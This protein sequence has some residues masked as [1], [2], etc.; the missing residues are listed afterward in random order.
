MNNIGEREIAGDEKTIIT[1]GKNDA[2]ASVYAGTPRIMERLDKLCEAIP[3]HYKLQGIRKNA[4]GHISAKNY[5]VSVA[6]LGLLTPAD[7]G[8]PAMSCGMGGRQRKAAQ[9]KGET[10]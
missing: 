10:I 5:N 4:K 7:S 1:F 6:M 2:F 3:T 8:I 9:M